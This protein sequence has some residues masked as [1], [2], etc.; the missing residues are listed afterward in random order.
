[1]PVQDTGLSKITL[2]TSASDVRARAG[3]RNDKMTWGDLAR[4]SKQACEELVERLKEKHT[5][6]PPW[7]RLSTQDIEFARESLYRKHKDFLTKYTEEDRKHLAEWLLYQRYN[8]CKRPEVQR[9]GSIMA[10]GS[11]GDTQAANGGTWTTKVDP[12]SGIVYHVNFSN[13]QDRLGKGWYR[14]TWF[15]EYL[16][17]KTG[18]PYYVDGRT[19]QSSW[20]KPPEHETFRPWNAVDDPFMKVPLDG[21]V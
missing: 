18:C 5:S 11:N 17:S 12:T 13:P 14:K 4:R 10:S 2:N 15:R 9:A 1:M 6:L 20:S 3:L 21:L 8:R 7:G 19:N 16:D